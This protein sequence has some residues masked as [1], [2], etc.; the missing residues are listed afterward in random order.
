M[1]TILG[2]YSLIASVFGF[3]ASGGTP[4]PTRCEL[5][6]SKS[7]RIML[8]D[9]STVVIDAKSM[10]ANGRSVLIAGTPV[11][12]WAPPGRSVENWKEP[13]GIGV[14][15]D[16]RGAF[17]IVPIPE[18][19]PDA[20]LPRVTSAGRH[21]WHFIFASGHMHLARFERATLWYGR[22]DGRQ[23][24]EVR[25][26]GEARGA[27][28][29]EANS[30]LVRTGDG[31]AFAYPY[32]RVRARVGVA[33]E[34]GIV[35]HRRAG[36]EWR[37]YDLPMSDAPSFVQLVP[38]RGGN[39]ILALIAVNAFEN[40]RPLGSSLFTAKLDTAWHRPIVAVRA[41]TTW[42][43]QWPMVAPGSD[44]TSV[45]AWRE[46]LYG[47]TWSRVAWGRLNSDGTVQ[48]GGIVADSIGMLGQTAMLRGSG[49]ETLWLAR[50][51]NSYD[52]FRVFA[53]AGTTLHDLGDVRQP[54]WASPAG[55]LERDGSIL[56]V[57]GRL[58]TTSVDIPAYSLTASLRITCSRRK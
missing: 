37:S 51:V 13:R 19:V 36:R 48:R 14:I 26:I 27:D 25:R 55:T 54:V 33:G 58:D 20:Q 11:N 8:P 39:A 53:L 5:Q 34:Q 57:G 56:T 52:A 42:Y 17:R 12:V 41:G 23:W 4:T 31:L 3:H 47:T 40:G 50:R 2:S 38:V 35:V 9:G 18:Q 22:F 29:L 46:R 7:Q 16:S 24:R 30:D 45:V 15:R 49:G 10:A 32:E 6:A 28:L 43:V 1:R 21:G 44:N